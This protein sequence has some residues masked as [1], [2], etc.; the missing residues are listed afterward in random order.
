MWR[1]VVWYIEKHIFNIYRR[2]TWNLI[3]NYWVFG[4]FYR[5]VFYK[6][7]KFG[8]L[9]LF[10][11]SGEGGKTP[12]QLGPLEKT[13]L[14]YVKLTLSKGPNWIGVFPPSPGDGNRSSYPNYS[15]F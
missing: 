10:P 2:Q 12:T 13:N 9:D 15:S 5:S 6:P 4:L 3:L 14:N 7:E 1:R 11:T 8:K